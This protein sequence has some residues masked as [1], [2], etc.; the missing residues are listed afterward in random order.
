MTEPIKSTPVKELNLFYATETDTA[1]VWE[2]YKNTAVARDLAFFI[3]GNVISDF[4][5][6]CHYQP[7]DD[8]WNGFN[9]CFYSWNDVWNANGIHDLKNELLSR[10][11]ASSSQ[12]C[13]DVIY[14]E[15]GGS[16]DSYLMIGGNCVDGYIWYRTIKQTSIMPITIT[17]KIIADNFDE[18]EGYYELS[19]DCEFIS[20]QLLNDKFDSTSTTK[21]LTELDNYWDDIDNSGVSNALFNTARFNPLVKGALQYFLFKLRSSVM[22]GKN[23][24][25]I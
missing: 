6:R 5:L 8:V 23:E 10:I 15:K 21:K 16:N 3:K 22:N 1:S 19:S 2:K 20:K 12:Y 11:S 25:L 7:S 24:I 18:S 13:G 17:A 14:Y 4:L 9:R